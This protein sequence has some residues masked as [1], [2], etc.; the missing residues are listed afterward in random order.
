[1]KNAWKNYWTSVR[2]RYSDQKEFKVFIITLIIGT[3]IALAATK[4]FLELAEALREELLEDW[5]HKV[6]SWVHNMRKPALTKFILVATEFGSVWG[7]LLLILLITWYVHIKEKGWRITL[8]ILAVLSTAGA[9]SFILKWIMDRERPQEVQMIEAGGLSFPSGHS[10]SSIAFYG[11]LIYLGWIHFRSKGVKITL[12]IA[13]SL[14]ILLIGFTRVYLGVHYPSDVAAGF[15]AG[16]G[17]LAFCIWI[18]NLLNHRRM[19]RLENTG[20]V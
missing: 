6:S 10:M 18:F 7:Y 11:F 2:E 5:D 19:G 3:V 8:E 1:M 20:P 15:A 9:M 12:T 17:W 16:L 4:V 13:L 14:F